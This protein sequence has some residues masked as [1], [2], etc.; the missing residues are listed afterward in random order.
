MR[1]G[2]RLSKIL[3][4][5]SFN[6]DCCFDVG[7]DHGKLTYAL[8]KEKNVKKVIASDISLPSLMKTKNL[9]EKSEFKTRVDYICCDG[10]T[11]YPKEQKA[12]YVIIVGMGGNEIVKIMEKIENFSAYSNFILEPMQDAA[13]LREYLLKNGFEINNDELIEERGKLYSIIKVG[14]KTGTCQKYKKED[15]WFGKDDVKNLTQEFKT[16]LLK[17]QQS[18]LK[19]QKYLNSLDL[20]KLNYVLQLLNK[21]NQR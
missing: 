10:L 3:S 2:K 20:Q 9:I 1:L 12:D 16:L 13:V 19:R 17:E 4:F 18:L 11:G 7:S 14:G 8:L 21:Y 6:A 5:V 15:V